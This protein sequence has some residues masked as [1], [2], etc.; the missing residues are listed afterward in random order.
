MLLPRDDFRWEDH[1]MWES[2][3]QYV[4]DWK[5]E[6]RGYVLEVDLHIPED[7][8]DLLDDSSLA[9]EKI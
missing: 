6:K 8:H 1:T 2:S 3:I 9:P 4:Q 7:K 5:N